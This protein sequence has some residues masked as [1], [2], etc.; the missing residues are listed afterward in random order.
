MVRGPAFPFLSDTF[1][2]NSTTKILYSQKY[3]INSKSS[4]CSRKAKPS[5]DLLLM[6]QPFLKHISSTKSL[7]CLSFLR[8]IFGFVCA[9][10][11]R[12]WLAN[13]VLPILE[14]TEF[15]TVVCQ[16][17]TSTW[18]RKGPINQTG[19]HN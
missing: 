5:I 4:S 19:Q 13:L 1:N 15:V 14:Y 7:L 6:T 18:A 16:F 10:T 2:D 17:R 8:S 3:F 11:N 12:N 9:L